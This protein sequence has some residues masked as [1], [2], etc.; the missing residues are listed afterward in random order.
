MIHVEAETGVVSK[1]PIN[2]I[3]IDFYVI[4]VPEVNCLPQNEIKIDYTTN[5]AAL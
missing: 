3:L 4:Y 2:D 1:I 5:I